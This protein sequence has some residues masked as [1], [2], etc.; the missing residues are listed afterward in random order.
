MRI[1]ALLVLTALAPGPNA[2]AEDFLAVLTKAPWPLEMLAWC[3]REVAPDAGVQQAGRQ[4]QARNGALLANIEAMA[5]GRVPPEIRKAADEASL[6]AIAAAV[7]AQAEQAAYCRQI[8]RVVDSG[9]YDI[10]QRADLR[11]ALE[12]IF[13][14]D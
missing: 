4:W 8:A 2:T 11:E 13:G 14:K 3:H 6:A 1:A 9:A 5:Q 12:R 7:R 10:D